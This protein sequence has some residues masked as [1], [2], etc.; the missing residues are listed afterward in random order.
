MSGHLYNSTVGR[1][2]WFV[3][4]FGLLEVVLKPLR[5]VFAPAIIPCLALRTFGFQGKEFRCFYARYNMTW[6]GER[7]VEIPVIK[8]TVDAHLPESVLEVGNVLSHYFPIKHRVVDKF[9]RGSRVINSDILD[10]SP[11]QKFEL[12]VSISTFEHIGFDDDSSGSSGQKIA[13]AIRHCRSLLSPKG[14]LIVTLPT[15]YNPDL[16]QLLEQGRL[17]A[18]RMDCLCRV[19]RRTWRQCDLSEALRHPY[20][21]AFP[22]ANGVVFAEFSALPS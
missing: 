9:E 16:D 12:I 19:G 11:D 20:R 17:E 21:S 1:V 8:D 22:Y 18:V 2:R 3:K 14:R 13:A 5:L 6:A 4:R 7:M 15:G 10:Y